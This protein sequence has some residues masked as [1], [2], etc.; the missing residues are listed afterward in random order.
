M[1]IVAIEGI[2]GCGKTTQAKMLVDR[3]ERNGCPAIY[4]RPLYF[5]LDHFCPKEA[6]N[7][8]SPRKNRISQFSNRKSL[9]TRKAIL[10][11]LG[12]FY[13]ITTYMLMKFHFRNKI[14]VCDRYFYQFF[15]DLFGKWSEYIV[16][17]FPK[18]E[19][20]LFLD[21]DLK[22]FYSR[23]SNSF[24]AFVSTDYYARLLDLYKRISQKH[25]FIKI[26]AS[27]DRETINEAI[28]M[29]LTHFMR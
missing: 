3:L 13:A 9:V 12:F 6:Q 8:V 17:V 4:V 25:G 7:L 21:G 14:V 18:P 16:K 23:M 15:Y 24:D 11:L 5:I 20:T 29:H 1:V 2:D 19:I 22:L 28:H 27:L 26:D 10:G